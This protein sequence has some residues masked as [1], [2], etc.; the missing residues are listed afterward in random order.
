M[1]SMFDRNM[2][3][4][5]YIQQPAPALAVVS[6][7]PARVERVTD[8]RQQASSLTDIMAG[9]N[10]PCTDSPEM[11]ILM[12]VMNVRDRQFAPS[13][14]TVPCAAVGC[15][16]ARSRFDSNCANSGVSF[17]TVNCSKDNGVTPPVKAAAGRRFRGGVFPPFY[18][19]HC[20]DSTRAGGRSISSRI[21]AG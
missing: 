5:I 7:F 10:S 8:D 15:E 2:W 18:R 16:L 20:L 19:C 11:A 3:A 6:K 1:A 14:S 4:F 17:A 12:N 13:T 21:C 9:G